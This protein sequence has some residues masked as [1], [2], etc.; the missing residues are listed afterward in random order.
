MLPDEAFVSGAA[1]YLVPGNI[2][3]RLDNRRTPGIVESVDLTNGLFRW[4]ITDFEHKGK[5]WDVPL[6][7]VVLFQFA[8][9][10]KSL[11]DAEATT[12]AQLI[13]SF[14]EILSI[15]TDIQHQRQTL[16]DINIIQAE[17]REWF[18][19]KSIFFNRQEKLNT[20]T[21]EG[22]AALMHD[23]QTYMQSKDLLK[24]ENKTADT[25]V[26]N[27][28]SGEWIKGIR[29]V[30]A[31]MG[32]MPYKD[33]IPRTRDI[34]RGPGTKDLRRKYLLHRLA[35]VWTYFEMLDIATIKLY[36]GMSTEKG[37][38]ND[39]PLSFLS[40][41][42]SKEVA[43]SFSAPNNMKHVKRTEFL[44]E[45]IPV[46]RLF[47]TY[48]ETEAMNKEYKEAEALVLPST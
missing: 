9:G 18:K 34:F 28:S 10:S 42:F 16:H 41:S 39:R 27:P 13:M 12:I 25:L 30:F 1:T 26:L 29:I 44:E 45:A 23:L 11:S 14:Q 8:D 36:R 48:L 46:R 37:W 6:E 5:F 38:S 22:S 4:R 15:P 31:E 40:F 32:L 24:Q 17:L 33:K 47:M 43:S 35:F 19:A 3:R 21:V 7:D 20:H 2:C